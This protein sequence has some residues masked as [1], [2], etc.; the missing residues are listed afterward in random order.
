M[1]DRLGKTFIFYCDGCACEVLNTLPV[2]NI[3][4]AESS[5]NTDF[6]TLRFSVENFVE[7]VENINEFLSH[8]LNSGQKT[9]GLY[10]RGVR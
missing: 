7:N 4:F 10:L 2:E 3:E 8:S 1:Q 6:E 9:H 5:E